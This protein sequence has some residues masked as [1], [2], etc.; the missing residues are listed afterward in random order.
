MKSAFSSGAKGLRASQELEK[1]HQ[2]K[3]FIRDVE[4]W[5]ENNGP[6]VGNESALWIHMYKMGWRKK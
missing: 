6:I 2:H 5:L 3:E 1:E 4:R